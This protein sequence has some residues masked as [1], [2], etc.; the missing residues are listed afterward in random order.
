MKKI[1]I[2]LLITAACLITPYFFSGS[3]TNEESLE[4]KEV[5]SEGYIDGY[6]EGYEEGF[7]YG[8]EEGY[9]L[10]YEEG[11]L[12]DEYNYGSSQI[13]KDKE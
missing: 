6:N 10:G 3:D 5:Y 11:S 4:Y 9:D 1:I 7:R 13:L 2:A 8:R 12:G